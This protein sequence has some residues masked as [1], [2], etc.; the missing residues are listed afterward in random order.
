MEKANE[1]KAVSRILKDLTGNAE[2]DDSQHVHTIKSLIEQRSCKTPYFVQDVVSAAGLE[3]AKS[4][5]SPKALV[6]KWRKVGK[7]IGELI[8]LCKSVANGLPV[9][10]VK[11]A[12]VTKSPSKSAKSRKVISPTDKA[13]KTKS[14]PQ[15]VARETGVGDLTAKLSAAF[16]GSFAGETKKKAVKAKARKPA[17]K[18]AKPESLQLF[19]VVMMRP[20]SVK[21]SHSD[22]AKSAP[23][24]RA[25]AYQEMRLAA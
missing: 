14:L 6:A 8:S 5:T 18:V 10:E 2:Y 13:P 21:V 3:K 23:V 7:P 12:K 17:A 11:L 1:I 4:V 22:L 19:A 16:A 20:K 15:Y 25:A 9:R 24:E